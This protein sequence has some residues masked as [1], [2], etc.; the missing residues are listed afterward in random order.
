MII[1]ERN[2]S[3]FSE[4]LFY[5]ELDD[6]SEG[7]RYC[8]VASTPSGI[9]S[10]EQEISGLEWYSRRLGIQCNVEII[11]NA[12]RYLKAKF[13]LIE[14]KVLSMQ[15]GYLK[16]IEYIESVIKHYIEVW[17]SYKSEKLAPVHGD[18]SM[19]GNII[20]G[21]DSVFIIDWEHFCKTGA[22]IGF[23]ALYF[24]FEILWFSYGNRT[25]S[26]QV[27]HHVALMIAILYEDGCLSDIYRDNYLGSI[28]EFI[29]NDEVIWLGQK[30][31]MPLKNFSIDSI[32]RIDNQICANLQK[33]PN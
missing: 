15:Y 20:I 5:R 23:D 19:E 7:A 24:M 32:E 21:T 25:V 4:I 13:P 26:N 8:K 17:S 28:V 33:I 10:I 2:F 6:S 18:L 16:N 31:K 27:I 14:G 9:K 1:V 11:R 30:S 22:P 29:N 3:H 12:D